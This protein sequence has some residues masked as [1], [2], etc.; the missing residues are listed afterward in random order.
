MPTRTSTANAAARDDLVEAVVGASRVL[1]A[2]AARSLADRS[3]DVTLPQYRLLVVLTAEGPHRVGDLAAALD[4]NP[5]TA[6]RLCDRLEGKGLVERQR[7]PTD[8]RAVQLVATD[9]GHRLV[10]QVMA[11]RRVEIGRILAT[12]SPEQHR[13][14]ADGLRLFSESAGEV[15]DRHWTVGWRR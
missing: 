14:V 3:D 12:M 13:Q 15:P 1:V 7:I 6:T 11:D 2:I 8:R 10:D 4:V 5:S 9:A